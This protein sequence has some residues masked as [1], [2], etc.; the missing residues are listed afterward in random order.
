MRLRDRQFRLY[1]H[2][3]ERGRDHHLDDATSQ[4]LSQLIT[5]TSICFRDSACMPLENLGDFGSISGYLGEE[6][7]FEA[8]F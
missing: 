4:Y 8:I 2:W 7:I 6:I 1:K 3:L 5:D